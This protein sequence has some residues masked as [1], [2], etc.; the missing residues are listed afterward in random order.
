MKAT[1]HWDTQN[2]Q[3]LQGFNHT[4]PLWS[5]LIK[6]Y[7]FHINKEITPWF[8][9]ISGTWGQVFNSNILYLNKTN[10]HVASDTSALMCIRSRRHLEALILNEP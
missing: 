9:L 8:H 7:F 4:L 6:I 5:G 3:T 2:V 1:E 10:T